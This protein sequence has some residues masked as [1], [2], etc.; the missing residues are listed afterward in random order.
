VVVPNLINQRLSAGIATSDIPFQGIRNLD[1]F[2]NIALNIQMEND[3]HRY[4]FIIISYRHIIWVIKSQAMGWAE[5]VAHLEK[6]RGAYR[7]LVGKPQ[8]KREFGR[9]RYRWKDNVKLDLKEI[10]WENVD[11]SGLAHDR[12]K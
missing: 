2:Y 1:M 12:N 5:H 6:R 8:G 11:C 4:N 10:G 7:V 9:P 3:G